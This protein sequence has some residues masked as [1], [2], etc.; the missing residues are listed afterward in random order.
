[1]PHGRPSSPERIIRSGHPVGRPYNGYV[2]SPLPQLTLYTR[3][4]CH[5]CA[6]TRAIVQGLLEDRAARALPV[7]RLTE[8]DIATNPDWE[9]AF[10]DR[11]P[12][13][14]LGGRR[15]ETA[16]SPAKIRAFLADVL[17]GSLV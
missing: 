5:L 8:R 6:E 7:A 9:R 17:E 2:T 10:F 12:V 15:L 11:L 4:G 14:E 1:V 13:L 16:V 3:D